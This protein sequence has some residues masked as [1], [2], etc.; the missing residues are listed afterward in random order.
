MRRFRVLILTILFMLTMALPA[1]AQGTQSNSRIQRTA[2]NIATSLCPT[3]NLE[4]VEKIRKIAGAKQTD[5]AHVVLAWY[6]TGDFVIFK[7]ILFITSLHLVTIN[8]KG[9]F[10]FTLASRS[11]DERQ[12]FR[13][14]QDTPR[15]FCFGEIRYG[16][17]TGREF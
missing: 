16:N 11:M 5:V 3:Q 1:M 13:L 14:I 9:I 12:E 7:I 17:D 10:T 6:L 15:L 2:F 8:I 4:K